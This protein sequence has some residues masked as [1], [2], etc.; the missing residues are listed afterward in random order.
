MR[1]RASDLRPLGWWPPPETRLIPD[2]CCCS[3]EYLP[4]F[5]GNGWWHLVPI[6]EPDQTPNPLR[7]WQ[8]AVPYW[9]TDK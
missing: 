4:V 9:A 1:L 3:T 2:W 6:L 5:E 7:R 8:S